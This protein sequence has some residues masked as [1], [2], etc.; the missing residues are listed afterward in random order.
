MLLLLFI[1]KGN[2]DTSAIPHFLANG[3][4]L[5]VALFV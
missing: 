4:A 2:G 3:S 1:S 5:V